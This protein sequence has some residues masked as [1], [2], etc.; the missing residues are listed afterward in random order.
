MTQACTSTP[1]DS[2][3]QTMVDALQK[4]APDIERVLIFKDHGIVIAKDNDTTEQS[5]NKF[6]KI[7]NEIDDKAQKIG[8]L[9]SLTVFCNHGEI[10]VSNVNGLYL[11]TS[12]PKHAD[13]RTIELFTKVLVPTVIKFLDQLT[14]SSKP[15]AIISES[16]PPLAN[17]RTSE[18]NDENFNAEIEKQIDKIVP[19]EPIFSTPHAVPEPQPQQFTI[20]EEGT[21][22]LDLSI[23]PIEQVLSN[24]ELKE[25]PQKLDIDD[26][27]PKITTPENKLTVERFDGLF[28]RPNTIRVD[29]ELIAKWKTEYKNKKIER[30]TLESPDKITANCKFEPITDKKYIGKGLIQIPESIQRALRVTLGQIVLTK[31]IISE[32]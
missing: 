30:I 7:F 9:Q 12:Y 27:T 11:T 29:K 15:N 19:E 32:E 2:A 6:I 31:P 1:H 24:Y 22:F 3:L 10:S 8:G 25:N 14:P 5:A 23:N 18:I 16:I 4:V 17:D 28:I 26:N 21:S 13:K 20:D